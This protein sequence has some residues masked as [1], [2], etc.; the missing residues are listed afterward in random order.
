MTFLVRRLYNRLA[1]E[2]LIVEMF[3]LSFHMVKGSALLSLGLNVWEAML[4]VIIGYSLCAAVC[5]G[6]GMP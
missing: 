1:K 5:L 2:M 4:V 3:D 6:T